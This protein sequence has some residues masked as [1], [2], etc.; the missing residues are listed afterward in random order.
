MTSLPR[1]RVRPFFLLCVALFHLLTL[2]ALWRLAHTVPSTG[3]AGTR[4][5]LLLEAL[6]EAPPLRTKTVPT[7]EV[8]R[9]K[10]NSRDPN[11]WDSLPELASDTTA[12]LALPNPIHIARNPAASAP[13]H[14]DESVLRRAAR[15][16]SPVGSARQMMG[17]EA[18]REGPRLVDT[19]N[20]LER[21]IAQA[22]KPSAHDLAQSRLR[23]LKRAACL[24]PGAVGGD[25]RSADGSAAIGGTGGFGAVGGIGGDTRWNFTVQQHNDC[26]P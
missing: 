1:R 3:P 13:L 8:R 26:P 17:T 24:P 23:A 16:A 11:P 25:Q 7:Q 15:D 6:T 22:H 5:E 14:L 12:A 18:A 21:E 19:P 10:T 20:R 4:V 2:D 9:R